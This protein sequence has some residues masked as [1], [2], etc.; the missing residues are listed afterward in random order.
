[1]GIAS[2]DLTGDGHPEV[3]LTS[4]GPNWLGSNAETPDRPTY[5][6]IS[7]DRGV[8]STNPTD[9]KSLPSTSW[10]DEFQDVNNDGL[11]D[12]FVT[13]GNVDAMSDYAMKDPN[14]LFLGQPDGTFI[15][16]AEAARVVSNARGRGGALVDLN[17]DGLLDMVVANRSAKAQ[18]WRN[19]GTGTPKQPEPMGD[20]LSVRLSESG[21]NRD[22][23]GAWI[24]VRVG[25]KVQTRE[26]T[27]GGGHAGGQL[28]PAH[29]GLGDGADAAGVEV[30]VQWPH[31]EWGPWMAASADTS[32]EVVRGMP[33]VQGS[34]PSDH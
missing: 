33:A 26:V 3:Y 19:I 29:F 23:I 22:G 12:L 7:L 28:G 20:W 21:P 15:D 6:D 18:V 30:R 5:R 25:G 31:H 16:K 4:Q 9:D 27:I 1:M 14:V 34:E 32:I 2:Y 10:H 24:E 13:K 8:M 17:N 11:I